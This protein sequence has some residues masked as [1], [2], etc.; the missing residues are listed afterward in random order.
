MGAHCF[1]FEP[2]YELHTL[3]PNAQFHST[4]SYLKSPFPIILPSSLPK[5]KHCHQSLASRRT[6][7]HN[8]GIFGT[9]DYLFRPLLPTINVVPVTTVPASSSHPRWLQQCKLESLRFHIVLVSIVN[10]FM[11][12][13]IHERKKGTELRSK[14][15][16]TRENEKSW[17][18]ICQTKNCRQQWS[19]AD[20]FGL[21][22]VFVLVE[23]SWNAMTRGDAGRGSE[24]ETGD[25]CG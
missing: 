22:S 2:R 13:T 18:L 1:L 7:G 9:I 17:Q 20:Y 12:K 21:L 24:G 25:W 19:P 14:L 3:S 23:S 11:W 5:R 4:A 15:I 10:M 6:I 8:L 16:R